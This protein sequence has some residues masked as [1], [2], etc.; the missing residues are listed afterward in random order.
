MEFDPHKRITPSEALI[1]PWII[2]G[3]PK[4]LAIEYLK[5]A[6]KIAFI[7]SSTDCLNDFKTCEIPCKFPESADSNSDLINTQQSSIN[8]K[9]LEIPILNTL[10]KIGSKKENIF[11]KNK[12]ISSKITLLT[13][14]TSSK[15][16]LG[17][18]EM[19]DTKNTKE[20]D[21]AKGEQNDQKDR[22]EKKDRTEKNV[23]LNPNSQ[24]A[25]LKDKKNILIKKPGEICN[26]K[27]QP[28]L[29][30]IKIDLNK[31]DD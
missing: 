9:S 15:D 4:N 17:K 10:N 13:Q 11:S 16:H 25:I 21:K 24:G 31:Y 2:E 27:E 28:K 3:L 19:N 14:R 18:N 22:K 7:A 6:G 20:K 1:H 23:K 30:H 8:I 26:L 5:I 29:L 12:E